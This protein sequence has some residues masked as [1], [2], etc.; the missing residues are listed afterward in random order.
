M[1]KQIQRIWTDEEVN[2]LTEN[3][4]VKTYEEISM[5]LDRTPYQIRNKANYMGL[6]SQNN[7]RLYSI[8]KDYFKRMTV[9]NCYWGGLIAA[10]GNVRNGNKLAIAVAL[11]DTDMLK[12]F[13]EDMQYTNPVKIYHDRASVTV[14]CKEIVRDLKK[15]FNVVERKSKILQPPNIKRLSLQLA[16]IKG[17]ID[18]D[19]S[20]DN[21]RITI[22]GT[23]SVLSWIK[24]IFD[25]LLPDTNYKK[26]EV[27]QIQPFLFSYKIGGNR[28]LLMKEHLANLET[29]HLERK[30]G[31]I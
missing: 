1:A 18:G 21:N 17:L 31:I 15:H 14:N 7:L 26:S 11:K 23:H 20:V 29:Y 28:Q 9:Q 6:C 19:G 13:V 5:L 24:S 22:Y 3:Y 12:A 27:C 16:Y 10:D 25:N 2:I 30:W 4:G 8:N